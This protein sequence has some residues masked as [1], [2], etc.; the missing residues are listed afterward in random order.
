MRKLILVI[1]I[2]S[3]IIISLPTIWHLLPNKQLNVFIVDKTVPDTSYREHKGLMWFLNNNKYYKNTQNEPYYASKDYFGFFPLNNKKYTIK[4]IPDNLN[5]Y[6]LIYIA[7]TYGVYED[8]Y[9]NKNKDGSRSEIIYGGLNKE[10][11]ERL[12]TAL[13]NG[14]PLI[15][16]F[17][18][19]ASPTGWYNR[20]YLY[21]I[22][23][24]EW[25]G[26]MGRYF[27]DLS[28]N[29][30]VPVWAVNNYEKI[31]NKKW[32]FT[33]SGFLFIS[34][35]DDVVVLEK[36][37]DF[38][39]NLCRVEYTEKGKNSYN[40]NK[41]IR[42]DYWFNIVKPRSNTE[43]H[44][45]Y[46]LNLNE[47]GIEKLEEK[48][49]PCTFPA[50]IKNKN[51]IYTSYYFAGDFS[52]NNK[53]SN[54]YK[55][56]GYDSYKKIFSFG[57]YEFFWKAYIP[58]LKT[59]LSEL[60]TEKTIVSVDN[61]VFFDGS[62]KLISRIEKKH[63]QVYSNNNWHDFFVKG[64][65]MGMATPGKWFTQFPKY[66]KTYLEWFE[67]ISNMNVN[68][69]RIYTLMDPSFYR[70]L[71][72]YNNSHSD[73][74][75]MLLQE[76]WPEENPYDKNYLDNRNQE[77]FLKE[78]EYVV[79]AIHGNI[80]ISD[81]IG[82]ANGKYI[83][84][85]S[86]YILGYLVGRELEP[87][88][89]ITTDEKNL[90]YH[91]KGSY[92]KGTENSSPT[93]NWLAWSCDYL[94][95][96]EENKYSWQHPVSIVSWP[97]L[98]PVEHDSEW[99]NFDDKSK[100]YNDK[101]VIDIKN[102]LLEPKM[103]A[104]FFGSY[105]IYPNYPDFMNNEK[106][107][108]LY[109]DEQGR[110][111]YGGYLKEFMEN[112][113]DYPALVAEFGLANGSG[114]AHY[115]PDSYHHGNIS[116]IDQG[117]GIVRMM[118][119]IKNENYMGGV[120]FEWMDEWAKKTWTTEPFMVPYER[121]VIWHNAIDPEQNYGILANESIP[122]E[123]P[124]Y[125][126]EDEGFIK[127]IELKHDETFLYLDIILDNKFNFDKNNLLLGID[128]YDREKG[129]FRYDEDISLKAPTGIEFLLKIEDKE[130]A[131]IYAVPSYNI[132][133]LQFASK[134][135]NNGI[136]ETINPIINKERITKNGHLINEIRQD[137]SKLNY[138]ELFGSHNNWNIEDN[139]IHI[140]LPWGKLNITDP[141]SALVLNDNGKF[142]DYPLR[143]EFKTVK[144]EGILLSGIITDFNKNITDIFPGNANIKKPPIYI[145][146]TWEIPEYQERL[147]KSYE[148][149]KK[150][151]SE[152]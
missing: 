58:M 87:E 115:N 123:N 10:E 104:G 148:I 110:F 74:P 116:E 22:L 134:K 38:E 120:I 125:T 90:N 146:E 75:L 55:I 51:D 102:I 138:G 92:L 53:I 1:I 70:A 64:I 3:L 147:K 82:R 11:I 63:F 67:K 79:D 112:H 5:N 128:T 127:K 48:N 91:Y 56:F 84:D 20:E 27:E 113:G 25:S 98:D 62:T 42:Y 17:N 130:N 135:S 46:N 59:I 109:T 60:S 132:G 89:V 99:N 52:D 118:K 129:E 21:E 96:Y 2:L 33:S 34:S 142:N 18:T 14:I 31:Y 24:L 44:A 8:E 37:K 136:F 40:I 121:H 124:E 97:T 149:I 76:V 30:E 108:D 140:R 88:E 81:R 54:F 106:K 94:L 41:K 72:K 71:L 80:T 47:T 119:A 83:A 57:E 117:K 141:S 144:T 139:I 68:T 151:F 35:S 13:Y 114:N 12:R 143:D 93:E 122:P 77:P 101:A 49:I 6:D 9:S 152:Q 28:K 107:Y 100:E 126:L 7:D 73:S 39:N 133:N 69:I 150:Y 50:V 26:W 85:V 4:D 66:E 78:I 111:R 86:K 145:W 32:D 16:E 36:E 137:G 65:N 19:F 95:E 15:A 23:G 45:F 131:G 29:V 103:K 43:V 61:N 105:H